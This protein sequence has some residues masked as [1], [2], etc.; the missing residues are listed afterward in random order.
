VWDGG[1]LPTEAEWNYATAGGS[2]QRAYPWSSPQSSLTID[3][4]YANYYATAFCVNPPTGA[5]DRVGSESPK[6]DGKWG[7]A[8]LAGNVSEWTLDY[9]NATLPTYTNPCSDCAN[10]SATTARCVR[11]GDWASVVAYVRGANRGVT[12]PDS[13]SFSIGVR[14]ARPP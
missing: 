7:H 2:E 6:G 12:G 1:Y 5:V 4:S 3:C 10:L 8:D 11:G 13:S 9:C 14:C